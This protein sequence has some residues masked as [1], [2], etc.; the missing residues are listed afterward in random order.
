MF[1]KKTVVIIGVFF[2]IIANI[3][4]LSVISQR[5][6][7]SGPGGFTI[8]V[9]APFQ[10]AIAGTSRFL[11]DI[12][13]HYF[14]LVLVSE[15]NDQLKNQLARAQEMK[16][17]WVEARM[18]N[19]RLR[20]LM[21]IGRG[22]AQELVY[23][24]VI[25]RDPTAWFKTVIINKGAKDNVAAGMPVLVPEGIVGQVVDVSGHY[26]KVLLI[27]DQNSAVD[28]LV[29]RT[30][31]RGLIKG[32]FADQCRLEFVL[33]KEDVQVEDAIVTSGLDKVFPKGLPIGTITDV[34]AETPD[35]FHTITVAPHV[36]FEKLEE[37]LVLRT[38]MDRPW[39]DDE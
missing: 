26:A 30:R 39:E 1:S 24:E 5:F 16:N 38:P 13:R 34:V 36:D 9:L 14:N 31:A 21:D 18:A 35:M 17:Q 33:R 15:E 22:F 12:W 19:D 29:Q 20:G 6:P 37:L 27:V 4:I 8:S 28:A 11:K 7:T 23:A 3:L 25:G 32:E 10:E 2:L